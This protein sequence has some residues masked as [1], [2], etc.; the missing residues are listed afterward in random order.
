[1]SSSVRLFALYSLYIFRIILCLLPQHGYIQPDEFFQ[2]TEPAAAKVLQCRAYLPWEVTREHPIR[3]MFFPVVLGQ[4]AFSLIKLI[5]SQPSGYLLLVL[6]RFIVTLMSFVC[7]WSLNGI[8][9]IL[10]RNED[11]VFYSRL[12]LA[13]SYVTLTYLTHTFSNSIETILFS[14]LLHNVMS[15]LKTSPNKS[16][17][18]TGAILALGFF[19]RPT[20][21]GF[22]AVPVLGS[23]TGGSIVPFRMDRNFSVLLRMSRSFSAVALAM[24]AWDTI[25]YKDVFD[26]WNVTYSNFWGKVVICPLNFIAY[27]IQTSNLARHGLHPRYLHLFNL[28]LIF[29][30]LALPL[31]CTILSTVKSFSAT[32]RSR[33][34]PEHWLIFALIVSV[35]LL[36]IFPHQEPRFLLPVTVIVCVVVGDRLNLKRFL[37][38]W[39]TFNVLCTVFYGFVHQ[40]GVTKSLFAFNHMI[41]NKEID[42]SNTSIIFANMYLPPQ[43]L[44]NAPR[45]LAVHDLSVAEYPASLMDQ[46]AVARQ[47]KGTIFVTA[48]SCLG[49]DVETMISH[50]QFS[51]VQLQQ[52]FFPH[53]SQE[54]LLHS[55]NILMTSGNFTDAFSFNIWKI[56]SS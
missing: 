38:P 44:M 54:V 6:P 19:N 2:F 8:L 25:Y 27:N 12:C 41:Q 24:I 34:K 9:K 45:D 52:Q 17:E 33:R 42:V 48:P 39:I 53:F 20:F 56:V 23:M 35:G 15:N 7:D 40:S 4:T 31:F 28:V 18:I 51:G 55:W 3:S 5:T 50:L 26:F 29:N 30:F 10:T 14:L 47:T 21:L 36:M 43:H 22:A 46:L 1:M 11:R 32:F 13:S 49:E 16:F 37:I